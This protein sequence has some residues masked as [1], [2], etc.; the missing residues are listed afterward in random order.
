MTEGGF[1]ALVLEA[2]RQYDSDWLAW[3]VEEICAR[4]RESNGD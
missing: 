4:W 2:E 3:K 1:V